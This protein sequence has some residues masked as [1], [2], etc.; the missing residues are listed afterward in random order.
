[1]SKNSNQTTG[2][3]A[4]L[5]SQTL[6]SS[7]ASKTAKSLAASALSQRSSTNQTVLPLLGRVRDWFGPLPEPATLVY[8]SEHDWL[9]LAVAML[10]RPQ[11]NPPGDFAKQLYLDSST[12]THPVFEQALNRIYTQDWPPH[13][14][15]PMRER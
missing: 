14:D 2:R 7:S 12:I 15:L 11:K 3:V 6:H 13:H 1:M 10:G 9:L 5:A 8:D 4:T